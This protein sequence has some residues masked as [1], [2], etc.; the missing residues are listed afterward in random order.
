M[1]GAHTHCLISNI[2]SGEGSDCLKW[3]LKM[4]VSLIFARIM[5]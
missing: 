1:K 2:P 3:R 4:I 5:K